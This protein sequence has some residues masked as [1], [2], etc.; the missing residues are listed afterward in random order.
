MKVVILAGGKGTRMRDATEDAIP[1]P[2][3]KVGEMPMLEHVIRIYAAQGFDEF[4]VAGGHLIEKIVEWNEERTPILKE[5]YGV[6]MVQVIDT[7]E[8]TQTGGRLKNLVDHGHLEYEPFMMTYGDGM[9]DI[10]LKALVQFHHFASLAG[11]TVT[12]TAVNPPSRFG[13][14]K[15]EQGFAKMFTE[16]TQADDGWINGGFYVIEPEALEMVNGDACRWEYDVLPVLAIQGRLAAYQHPGF[17][18]MCDTWRDLQVLTKM[19]EESAPWLRMESNNA[20]TP[21]TV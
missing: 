16:K 2:M 20:F 12:L 7:G 3:V 15:I 18:Q 9:A 13:M 19:Y 14:L 17:F 6:A 4:I 10:N 1:K 21:F 8:E 5:H 11:S